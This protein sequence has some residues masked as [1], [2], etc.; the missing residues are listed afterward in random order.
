MSWIQ[1]LIFTITDLFLKLKAP[2]APIRRGK[3]L[4]EIKRDSFNVPKF[5]N[6]RSLLQ[7]SHKTFRKS[8]NSKNLWLLKFSMDRQFSFIINLVDV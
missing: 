4:L 7:I 1:F 3:T 8:K 6:P 5:Q 2:S